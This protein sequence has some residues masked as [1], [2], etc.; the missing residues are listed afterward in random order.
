MLGYLGMG[1]V[2]MVYYFL[3]VTYP[4]KIAEGEPGYDEDNGYLPAVDDEFT[5]NIFSTWW[6]P[7]LNKAEVVD[8]TVDGKKELEDSD[9]IVKADDELAA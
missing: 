2:C 7:V 5:D 8:D 4:K 1:A 3:Q 6:D 9:E